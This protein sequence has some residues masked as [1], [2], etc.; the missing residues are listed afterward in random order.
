MKK[1]L[2]TFIIAIFYLS[3]NISFGQ[4]LILCGS[5]YFTNA[6]NL[7]D[8]NTSTATV[9]ENS[10]VPASICIKLNES[11]Y[12]KT[13]TINIKNL[14]STDF[15]I[16]V[17][18]EP[19]DYSSDYY[20]IVYGA[21]YNNS[22]GVGEATIDVNQYARYIQLWEFNQGSLELYE[23]TVDAELRETN[24]T[25]DD[26]GNRTSRYTVVTPKSVGN[27]EEAEP[28]SFSL[29][30][31]SEIL[32]YPNPTSGILNFA[33]ISKK[34]VD[35]PEIKVK[36]YSVTGSLI[37]EKEFQSE[38]FTIDLSNE[39]N[40]SYILDMEVNGKKQEFKVIKQ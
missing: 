23:L 17:S 25:Y 24:Y 13:F 15:K 38:Y 19:L 1:I 20:E 27:K 21:I 40:G 3:S 5:E 31:N 2:I 22:S 36:V 30:E 14:T 39:Q 37:L 35:N 29:D 7:I 26:A 8:N 33:L 6:A 9:R 16:T 32:L 28:E 12:I 11:N 34:E 10:G 4:N 18:K